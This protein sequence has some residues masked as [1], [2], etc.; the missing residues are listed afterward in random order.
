MGPLTKALSAL[1]RVEVPPFAVASQSDVRQLH[2][3][4]VP[5]DDRKVAAAAIPCCTDL[6]M[7]DAAR[8]TE[9]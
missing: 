6:A 2:L 1:L 4:L 8:G 7:R 5:S 9:T 3:D